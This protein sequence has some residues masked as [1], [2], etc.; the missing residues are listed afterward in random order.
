MREFSRKFGPKTAGHPS[1]G[2]QCAACREPFKEGD[3]TTLIALGPGDDPEAQRKA[4]EGR[5][6]NAVAVEVH[7]ACAGISETEN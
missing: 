4:L 5:A 6:Y 7:W 3:Y 1:I 2:M